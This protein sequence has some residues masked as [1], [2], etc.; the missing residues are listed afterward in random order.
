MK[1]FGFGQ[2]VYRW[3][4]QRLLK[5]RGRYVSDI[6]LPD[7]CIGYVLRSPHAHAEIKSID[8][9]RASEAEGVVLALTGEDYLSAGLGNTKCHLNRRR[10][11]GSKLFYAPQPA[12]VHDK[13][14][15]VG[16]PVAFIVA[17][18][19]HA[20][21]DGAELIEVEYEPL[22]SVTRAAEA[23]LEGAP[24]IWEGFDN[25]ISNIHDIG[26]AESVALA[27]S[28]ADLIVKERFDVSR[29]TACALEPRGAIGDYDRE[30]D[31]YTLYSDTQSPHALRDVHAN[32]IFNISIDQIH[33]IAGD[34][35]GAFGAKSG[36]YIEQRLCLWASKC[37]DR[38]VKW[39]S[40]RNEGFQSDTHGRDNL[41]EAELALDRD[42]NFLA[43]RVKSFANVG[44][45]LSTDRGLFPTFQNL[46]TL[47]GVYK[48]PAIHVTVTAV[49]TNTNQTAP[50][51]GAGR[52]EAAYVIEGLVEAAAQRMN[53]D[54]MELRRRNT[55]SPEQMPFVTGLTFT[56]DCGNFNRNLNDALAAADYENFERRRAAAKE[57]GRIRGLGVANV[58]ERAADGPR[59]E[60]VKLS[61][62][63]DAKLTIVA[64][65]KNQGQGHETMYRQIIGDRLRVSPEDIQFIDGDTRLLERGTGSFGSR[66]AAIG[67]GAVVKALDRIIA[68]GKAIAGHKF[69]TDPADIDFH[70]DAFHHAG[71]NHRLALNDVIRMSFDSGQIPSEMATGMTETGEYETNGPNF[72][73]G[74]HVCEV[75]ID[76]ETG[77]VAIVGYWSVEDFGTV[78]NPLTLEGQ[79]H[80][81]IAQGVGQALFEQIVYEPESGQLLTATFQDY[82][83]PRADNFCTIELRE[84][85]VPTRQNPLGVK[86]AGEA[87]TV[88]ALPAV[89]NAVNNALTSLGVE[90]LE[91]PLSSEKVWRAIHSR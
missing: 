34:V 45:Y 63:S 36:P 86:G 82:C 61:F 47:A 37:L 57:G 12:L 6:S 20:A 81:G 65:T 30:R 14:R 50:Y 58:I 4:D 89:I 8:T 55:I 24:K 3:E 75:E 32:E 40:S 21:M 18:N 1:K 38:P 42:G 17:E 43:L 39:T 71:T 7:Q 48:T 44:A 66:S 35:G 56:Y 25:N 2:P 49:F 88:G 59:P 85:P 70:G 73:N 28:K 90:R 52:P 62:D 41:F 78:I 91:M 27:F 69:D 29:V 79:I 9:T 11:D 72:P 13:V 83:M 33:V 54:P 15:S 46:G 10:P 23:I 87:G 74:C 67:G 5:G 51:R 76:P 80:G 31:Q 53:L 64:G 77:L 22:A 60:F 16:D 26:D 84:N 19:I 68:K